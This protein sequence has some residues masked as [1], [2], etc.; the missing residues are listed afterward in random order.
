MKLNKGAVLEANK[1][2]M[3]ITGESKTAYQGYYEYKGKP[4]GQ[5][6]LAKDA[7]D[8]MHISKSIKIISNEKREEG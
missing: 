5:C 7:F 2:I 6:S 4:V 8:N 3:V 1:M